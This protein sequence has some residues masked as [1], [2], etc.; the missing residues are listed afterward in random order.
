MEPNPAL[1]AGISYFS[2][3]AFVAAGRSLPENK[4]L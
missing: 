4:A 1:V 3:K 2:M